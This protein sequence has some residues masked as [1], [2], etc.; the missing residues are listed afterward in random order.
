M[1]ISTTILKTLT[2]VAEANDE[3]PKARLAAALVKSNKIMSIGINRKKTDPL[4]AK[5]GKNKESIFLHAEI[6][7]IKNALREYDVEDLKNATLYICRVKRSGQKTNKWVWGLAK[8]CEGCSRAIVEF[9]IK[10]VVYTTDT[11]NVF[12][13]I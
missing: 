9:G 5:Y 6:N 3:F 11:H 10:N 13:V 2:K 8:P 7:C 4:Q 12:E 1:K